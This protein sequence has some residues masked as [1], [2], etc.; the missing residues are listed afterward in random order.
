MGWTAHFTR[1]TFILMT[2]EAAEVLGRVVAALTDREVPRLGWPTSVVPLRGVRIEAIA[3]DSA[4]TVVVTDGSA[5]A[6]ARLDLESREVVISSSGGDAQLRRRLRCHT[7][8]FVADRNDFDHRRGL[9]T[10]PAP[11]DF[12]E[13]DPGTWTSMQ[14]LADVVDDDW[15]P[16]EPR[17]REPSG[18]ASFYAT[19]HRFND[20]LPNS[21]AVATTQHSDPLRG[22]RWSA[23]P[24]TPGQPAPAEE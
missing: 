12:D 18:W 6:S 11:P 7:L 13:H 17:D 24:A 19:A 15:Y 3:H 5:E 20:R 16:P 10:R 4:V 8:E 1:T 22:E 23:G 9:M 2:N 14:E 21:D